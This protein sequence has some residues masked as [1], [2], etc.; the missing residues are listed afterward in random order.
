MHRELKI[1]H[2]FLFE[3]VPGESDLISSLVY[4]LKS[5]RCISALNYFSKVLIVQ[6]MESQ[7]KTKEFGWVLPLPGSTKK[8]AHAKLIANQVALQTGLKNVDL[9]E[10]TN[11]QISQK[12]KALRQR[13]QIQMTFRPA[14]VCEQ[15]T[16]DL[17]SKP[18]IIYVDD[19][20]TTGN[21]F[22]SAVEAVGA[23]GLP[24]LLTL[25]YRPPK[26]NLGQRPGLLLRD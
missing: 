10:K 14:A 3:W 6:V 2:Y 17:M 1:P 7:L 13:K 4:Q 23:Q 22:I 9:L 5:S 12:E 19:I 8:S 21:T 26:S 25:F 24:C 16:T 18:N 20:L 11:N 15:I